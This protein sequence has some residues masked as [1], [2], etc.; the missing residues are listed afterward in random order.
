MPE[1]SLAR[2]VSL[3]QLAGYSRNLNNCGAVLI[4]SMAYRPQGIEG[5][6]AGIPHGDVN[7][8]SQHRSYP[9]GYLQLGVLRSMAHSLGGTGRRNY[10]SSVPFSHR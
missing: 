8:H 6:L 1:L 9:S 2:K 3:A 10:F 5:L 4:K 7:G